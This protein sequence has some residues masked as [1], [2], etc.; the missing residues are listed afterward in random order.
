MRQ[1]LCAVLVTI[2]PVLAQVTIN[3]LPTREF[4]QPTLSIP[5]QS[6]APNLVEGRELYNPTAIAFDASVTPPHVYIVDTGNNRVLGWSNANLLTQGNFADL[7]IG[8]PNYY[9]TFPLGPGTSVSTG[10]NI[11]TGIAVDASGN[12]YVADSGNNRIL[13]FKTPYKQQAGDLPVD[14]VIGQ[15]TSSS[16]TSAN[17]NL[18]SPNATT[19]NLG[20]AGD[21]ATGLILTTGL[22]MDGQGNLWVADVGN[23]RVLGFPPSSL[24]AN[25]SLPAASVVLGQNSFTSNQLPSTNQTQTNLGFLYEPSGVAVDSQGNLYVTDQAGRAIQYLAPIQIGESGSKVLGIP[26]IPTSQSQI[27]TYPT[28]T[29]LGSINSG[30]G[31]TGS[32]QG[33]FVLNGSGG[34]SVFVCDL[35]QNRVVRYDTFAASWTAASPPSSPLQN[36]ITGQ[37]SSTTGQANQGQVNPSN[38]TLH[39]PIAGAINPSNGEM[40]IVD[41][42]NH[43]VVAFANQGGGVYNT[44][45]RVVGQTDFIYG[46]PN[47]IVGSELWINGGGGIAIDS[48]STPPHLYIADSL[49]NRILG[50]KNAYSVGIGG[51]GV[52]TQ[53]ADLVIGQTDLFHSTVNSPNGA[54]GQP[55]ATG[56]YQPVGVTV[57]ANGNLWVADSGNGRVVRFPAPFSQPAGSVPTATVVLGQPDFVTYNTGASQFS[58]IQPF[59]VAIFSDGGPPGSGSLAVSDVGAN[60]ILTFNRPSGGDFMATG[61]AAQFVVGQPTFSQVSAGGGSS[62][63]NSPRHLAVDSSDRLYVCD[64]NNNRL[65]VF[66][67]PAANTPSAALEVGIGQPQGVIVSFITGASWV[68]SYNSNA[69]YQLPEFQTL[70]STDEFTQTISSYFPLAVALDPFDNVIVADSANRVTFYFGQLYYR[71]TASYAAGVG[72]TAGPTPGMLVEIAREG[73]NGCSN[74]AFNLTPSY[75]TG[76]IQ[77]TA[78][79]WPTTVNNIQVTVAGFPAPIFRIDPAVIYFEIPNE[80]PQ[81]G[82][83]VFIVTNTSTGQ[84]LAVNTFNM[85]P[86]SPGLYTSNSAGT[87]QVAASVYDSNGNYLGANSPSIPTTPGGTITL[88]LTGAGYVPNLSPDG[89]APGGSAYPQFSPTVFI[90]AELAKVTASQ[91]S[92]QFPGLWQVNVV[93]PSDTPAST[94]QPV[95]VI[96]E[97]DDFNSNIG[98]GTTFNG[99]GSPGSDQDLTVPNGLVTT[100]YVK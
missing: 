22:A 96:V 37:P 30:A 44:A 92:P 38:Q 70:Q 81:S 35:P 91:L 29:T 41:Q 68:T 61:Q 54:I 83:A 94:I 11:P 16:G 33:V 43:R 21:A 76:S 87:G 79:P 34:A 2:V 97:L 23:N 69:V 19:L 42:G 45:S 24:T 36:G 46:T 15:K 4:G 3:G 89:T 65:I 18:Q 58:M 60:R 28:A 1:L 49:N 39:Y 85:Q 32:P 72:L 95:S 74:F 86:A 25:T 98:A 88:W 73:C 10:L 12:V 77:N 26:P 62:Q 14:L 20:S 78:P 17:Q 64:Y 80:A 31:I 47:L 6:A 59:G 55:S 27:I 5:I 75:G 71:S 99:N 7:V 57:D 63:L 66:S 50:F 56:L 40:W 52:L 93:V 53:T 84:I 67:K 48:N 90:N 100:I 8:Q 82:P 13:R 51:S 9:S